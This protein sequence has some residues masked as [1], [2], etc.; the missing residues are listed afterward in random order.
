MMQILFETNIREMMT[1]ISN[2]NAETRESVYFHK[3]SA[4]FPFEFY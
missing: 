3:L 4:T 2:T 1:I